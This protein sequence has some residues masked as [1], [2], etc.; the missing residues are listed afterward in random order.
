[1]AGSPPFEKTAHVTVYPTYSFPKGFECA[2][3]YLHSLN[4][5]TFFMSNI[6]ILT[7]SVL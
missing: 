7:I 2:R 1:M 5:K 4:S 3:L 6:F